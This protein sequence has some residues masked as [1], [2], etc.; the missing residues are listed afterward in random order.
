MTTSTKSR[1]ST[2]ARRPLPNPGIAAGVLA[3][4]LAGAVIVSGFV[5]LTLTPMMCS[6]LLR[7]NP[8]PNR[9]D[10]GM[11]RVLVALSNGYGRALRWVL[12]QRWIV[13]VVMAG[14]R[15]RGQWSRPLGSRGRR[16]RPGRIR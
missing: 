15:D 14:F 16:G 3:L 11:E 4:T 8:S 6:K 9:F 7:H 10:R 1:P 12:T 5:A 13:L 2:I